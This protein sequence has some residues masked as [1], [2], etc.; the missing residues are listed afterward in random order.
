MNAL[1]LD[2]VEK[3]F[4][5]VRALAGITAQLRAGQ[6][7]LVSGPNGAGKSTL[8][9]ILAGL[10]RPT[11]GR[12]AVLGEDPFRSSGAAV[13]GQVGYLGPETALYGELTVA[14]NLE[15]CARLQRA[16]ARRVPLQLA[17]LGLEDMADRRVRTLSSGYRRRAGLARALLAHPPVLLLDEP[18]NG[19]D[20]EASDHLVRALNQL[21]DRGGT[22]LVAAHAVGAYAGLFDHHLRIVA[23]HLEPPGAA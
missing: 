10:T 20:S 17:A 16:P 5:R 1:E 23:G 7:V 8:L 3:R 12:I 4:G 14:E 9:R 21:R 2:S 22:A 15:F 13:R 18:W 11:R 19:L 6:L